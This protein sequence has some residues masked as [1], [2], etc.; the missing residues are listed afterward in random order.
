MADP[1]ISAIILNFKFLLR[2]VYPN[3]ASPDSIASSP[4]L[5][6]PA[7][8]FWGFLSFSAYVYALLI[9][10]ADNLVETGG[11]ALIYTLGLTLRTG[12]GKQKRDGAL[13]IPRPDKRTFKGTT[14]SVQSFQW[15]R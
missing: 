3:R 13:L 15:C 1:Q 14:K 2:T 7:V 11:Y 4:V 5:S 10:T 8:T 12:G 9:V 6:S